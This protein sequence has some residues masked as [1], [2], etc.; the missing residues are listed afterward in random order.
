MAAFFDC[1][2]SPGNEVRGNRRVRRIDPDLELPL[3]FLRRYL[4]YLNRRPVSTSNSQFLSK[5]LAGLKSLTNIFEGRSDPALDRIRAVLNALTEANLFQLAPVAEEDLRT[6]VST[7]VPRDLVCST[8]P[9]SPHFLRDARRTLLAFGPGIGI[10]DEIICY[11]ISSCLRGLGSDITVLS[12]YE[13]LWNHVPG[14][15]GVRTYHSS[16]EF[17]EQIRTGGGEGGWDLAIMVDFENPALWPAISRETAVH[18][19]AEIAMGVRSVTALDRGRSQ[20]H[21]MPDCD[22]YFQNYYDCLNHIMSWLGASDLRSH[23]QAQLR[24]ESHPNRHEF[25]VLVSP[26]TSKFNASQRYWGKLLASVAAIDTDVTVRFRIETGPN[27]AT[28]AFAMEL[29]KVAAASAPPGVSFDLA[30]SK[31]RNASLTEFFDCL[32]QADAVIAADS[33][34]A[35]AAP[36]FRVPAMIIGRDGVENWRVPDANNFYFRMGDAIPDVALTVRELIRELIGAASPDVRPLHRV[37]PECRDLQ[38]ASD[39]LA[40]ALFSA[41]QNLLR[42]R[43]DWTACHH[44]Y[45]R[46]AAELKHWPACFDA[47]LNDK[48]YEHL[49]GP[50]PEVHD[51]RDIDSEPALLLH[52]QDRFQ[53]WNNSNLRKYLRGFHRSSVTREAF[54]AV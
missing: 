46:V 21:R 4:F 49:M 11:P 20:L 52:L 28:E 8:C 42:I 6:L 15:T 37:R 2:G 17:I 36:A 3:T 13:G 7:K 38:R 51:D 23:R 27:Q 43:E 35:H 44:A 50:W 30:P 41:D 18:R 12:G 1:E 47:M 48:A 40:G 53:N 25:V 31:G 39:R 9:P 34:L 29:A 54:Y 10:G 14:V 33:F 16:R 19:Y 24:P 32:K 22:P 26:F 5:R 45:C